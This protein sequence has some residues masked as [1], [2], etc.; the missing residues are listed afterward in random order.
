MR[1]RIDRIVVRGA[2]EAPDA[3][4]FEAA[5]RAE[6]THALDGMLPPTHADRPVRLIQATAP[7]GAAP[8][9]AIAAALRS[10]LGS[11]P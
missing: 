3:A 7:P 2:S 10:A 4:G 11:V 9:P 6:V 5:V 1:V 8:A